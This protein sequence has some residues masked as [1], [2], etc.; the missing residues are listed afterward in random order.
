MSAKELKAA[1][2]AKTLQSA[3]VEI[4]DVGRVM[5]R[6][7]TVA[8]LDLV[9]YES[10]ADARAKNVA[11][12]IFTEDGAERVFNPDDETDIAIIKRLGARTINRI[13]SALATK[14]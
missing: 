6:E 14:N 5:V 12:A 2:A 13:T 3:V 7:L 11:L 4:P 10:T 1:F 9:D 8:D